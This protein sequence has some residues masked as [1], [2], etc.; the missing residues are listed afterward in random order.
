MPA[1]MIQAELEHIRTIIGTDESLAQAYPVIG[2]MMSGF[3]VDRV[4]QTY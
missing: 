2:K 4:R 1:V 3:A